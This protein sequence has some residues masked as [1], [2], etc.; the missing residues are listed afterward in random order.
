L[1]KTNNS[2]ILNDLKQSL[3]NN[4]PDIIESVI[5]FGSRYTGENKE[6][7]D[8]DILII[9]NKDYDWKLEEKIFAV[10]YEIDLKYDIL[11][12]VKLISTNELNSIR[13][14]QLFI[15]NAIEKGVRL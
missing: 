2:D 10:C 8:Y 14:K 13:G 6:Y 7:S 3:I 1:I 15:L 9:L 4:F 5:F 12:D 11:T